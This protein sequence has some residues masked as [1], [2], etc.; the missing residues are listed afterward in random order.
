MPRL[1]KQRPLNAKQVPNRS[2]GN[3]PAQARDGGPT[4][5][6]CLSTHYFLP[7]LLCCLL[8]GSLAIIL[9]H[10][11]AYPPNRLS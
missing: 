11:C 2:A 8:P 4:R 10:P 6:L 3:G 7:R 5:C 1:L 9:R